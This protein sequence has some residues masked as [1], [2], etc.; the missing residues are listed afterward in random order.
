ML[1]Y[2]ITS[3]LSIDIDATTLCNTIIDFE[4]TADDVCLKIE[5][6]DGL[7]GI[8]K[9]TLENLI[10]FSNDTT[11]VKTAI[12]VIDSSVLRIN[13]VRTKTPNWS[14]AGSIFLNIKG[15]D[16]GWIS[17]VY[18]AADKPIVV[19]PIP[20][21]HTASGIGIDHHN[22]HNLYL[23]STGSYPVITFATGLILTQV[24]F[25]G[26]QAWVAGT[27]GLYWSDTT[28]AAISNG[29]Y[30][31]N[32]RYEQTAD[33]TKYLIYIAHNY[34]LQGLS[35]SGGQGGDRNGFYLRKVSN[36][37]INN[38][39]YTSTTKVALDA[40]STCGV[41]AITNCF[42]QAG[43]TVS[44]PDHQL[45]LGLPKL[46]NTGALPPSAFYD[47]SANA[48]GWIVGNQETF[49]PTLNSFTIVLGGG[50][51]TATGYKIAVGARYFVTIVITPSGGATIASTKNVSYIT[52]MP[53]ATSDH[54]DVCNAVDSAT[55]PLGEGRIHTTAW[56]TPTWGA[57]SNT[58]IISGNYR[59]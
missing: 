11:Y 36:I 19:E 5:R 8:S 20:A 2:L 13:N 14:G 57:T 33:G 32:I 22:F 10:F 38:F 16:N 39:Y 48:A 1:T 29:L 45:M 26:A 31:E 30:L 37:H 6:A 56:L 54:D 7:S 3:T 43:S 59:T 47:T 18:A 25:T 49:T 4:P 50:A 55:N 40:D 9:T 21:P 51:V 12:Q 27:Y 17:D 41:I 42:W 46:P 34:V 15:R 44:L 58:I 53:T 24:S 52:G 35:I 28:S 23:I